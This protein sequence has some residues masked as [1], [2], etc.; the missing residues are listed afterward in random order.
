MSYQE[1][2]TVMSVI[3]GALIL[4]SYFIYT[5]SKYQ[6]G[7]VTEGDLKFWAGSMLL[8]IAIGIAVTIAI[9]IIFH[10]LLSVAIAAKAKI[11]NAD[12]DD[13]EIERNIKIEMT[14][15][16]MDKLIELK[17]SMISFGVA[18]AG[19]M[20]ALILLVLDYSPVIMLNVMFVSFSVGSMLEGLAQLYF[21]RR[22]ITHG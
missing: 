17:S 20:L 15:D 10:I 18:G 1:K 19:F 9:Q 2:K 4:I 22:G 13:E 7:I 14:T 11:Q 3:T 12:C 5:N 8:F 16:E 21:Y 6:S